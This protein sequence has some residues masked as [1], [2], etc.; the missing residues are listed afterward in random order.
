MINLKILGLVLIGLG[1]YIFAD[2][3]GSILVQPKQPFFWFQF[4]RVFRSSVGVILVV[5]GTYLLLQP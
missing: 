2:G 4:I 1:S 3:V 5:L